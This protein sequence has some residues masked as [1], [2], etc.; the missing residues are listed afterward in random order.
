MSGFLGKILGGGAE[1][2]GKG[3]GEIIESVGNTVDKFVQTPEEKAQLK[4]EL[5]KEISKR[6]DADAAS[7]SWLSR[8]I[9]PLLV[10]WAVVIFTSLLF[11]DGNIGSFVVREAYLPIFETML[12]TIIGGYFVLRSVDKRG[13]IR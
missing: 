6:W 7:K 2:A 5:E 3:V 4:A 9:R 11:A 13:R 10:L 8:N 1:G 12:I